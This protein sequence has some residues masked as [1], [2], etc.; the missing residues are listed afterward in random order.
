MKSARGRERGED[1][2]EIVGAREHDLRVERLVLQKH[3]LVVFTGP[4]GSDI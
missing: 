3:A 2:I 1:V 4:S